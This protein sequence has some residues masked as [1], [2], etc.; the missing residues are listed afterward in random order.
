MRFATELRRRGHE[1][2]V[3]TR[4]PASRNPAAPDLP[5]TGVSGGSLAIAAGVAAEVAAGGFSD[6][7]IEY[8][9][10]MW[11]PSRFGSPA[12]PFLAAQLKRQ[13][14]SISLMIHEPFT[15][16][17]GRPDLLI[18]A[19]LLRLQLGAVLPSCDRC[20]VTTETRLPLVAGA[21]AALSPARPLSVMRIGPNALP[22]PGHPTRAYRMGFFATLA[23]G[24]RFDIA[25]SALEETSRLYPRAE[26]LLIGDVATAGP[27]AAAALKDRIARSPV[28]AQIRLTGKLS[29]QEIAA[30]VATLDLYL[31]T[32]NTG[33][34]TRSSTLPLALGSGVPAVAIR[35][36]ETDPIFVHGDN[37]FFADSLD[38]AAFARA[39]TKV[40]A[41]HELAARLSLGGQRLYREHLA[42]DRIVDRALDVIQAP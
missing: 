37:V 21:V 22:A 28:A 24:K 39:A 40:F 38:G 9:P 4:A 20:F 5:V 23:I 36:P 17:Y 13:G 19:A 27:R 11:G 1:A 42:W 16:W 41:D 3:F 29:L 25:I 31:F 10:Q 7:V 30:T 26:L 8:A 34:N 2:A 18:G 12:L 32:M 33:A 35:G 14:I 15:P 6:A